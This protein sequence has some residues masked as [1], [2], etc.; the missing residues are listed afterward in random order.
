MFSV[1][2]SCSVLAVVAVVLAVVA[3]CV[4]DSEVNS[5]VSRVVKCDIDDIAVGVSV[6]EF[7]ELH[8]LVSEFEK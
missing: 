5:V 8:V 6:G 4:A 2:T 1:V 3:L 7:N